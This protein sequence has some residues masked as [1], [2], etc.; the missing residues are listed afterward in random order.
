MKI[1]KGTLLCVEISALEDEG[2]YKFYK[3]RNLLIKKDL[4][5]SNDEDLDIF[6]RD[7]LK[8]HKKRLTLAITNTFDFSE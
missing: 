1:K 3:K 7:E 6:L 4:F 2:I 5:F 8:S